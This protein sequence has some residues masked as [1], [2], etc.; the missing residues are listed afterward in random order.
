M[1]IVALD[2]SVLGV[3]GSGIA[4]DLFRADVGTRCWIIV[5]LT[6]YLNAGLPPAGEDSEI[7]DLRI[8]FYVWSA[9]ASAKR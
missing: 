9:C 5:L 7:N 3:E 2:P 8:E 1:V 6:A 4:L